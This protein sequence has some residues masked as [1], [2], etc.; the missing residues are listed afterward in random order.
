MRPLFRRPSPRR[1]GLLSQREQGAADVRQ[2]ACADVAAGTKSGRFPMIPLSFAQRR[3]WFIQ[4][5]EGPSA[6]Y[7]VPVS[8]RLTGAVD[9]AALTAAL[10]DVLERHEVLRTTYGVEDG[11]PHQRI[12]DLA[13][14]DWSLQTVELPD[15]ATSADLAAAVAGVFGY[16]FDLSV[17][18]PIRA[19]L[20]SAGPGEHA[21]A[22]VLH[23]IASDGASKRPLAQDLSTAYAARCEGR[24][25]VWE[26]LP[27]QYA[28]YAL[29]QREL[30][31]DDSDPDSMGA[32]QVA[33]W[34]EA[35]QDIPEELE[36]PLDHPRPAVPSHRGLSM[37]FAVS[38][39]VHAHIQ[40]LA[41]A[42]G[43]TTFMVFQ[44]VLAMTLSK[45]GAGTDVPVGAAVAGRSD[46]ALRDLVGF[47]VNTLVLRTD[48]SGDPTFREVLRRV[49]ETSLSAF[50]HQ[51]VPFEKLV[52]ELAPARSL[53]RHPLFQ[54]M[55][56]VE[57][58]AQEAVE[59]PGIRA[60]SL[61]DV[62]TDDTA[63]RLKKVA[64]FDLEI[65]VDEMFAEDGAAAGLRGSV[66]VAA[67]LFEEGSA[68][69]FAERLTRALATLIA[70]PDTQLSG[71]DILDDAER[72]C[73]LTEWNDTEAG[74]DAA[75][76]PEQFEAHAKLTPDAVAAVFEGTELTY[77]ELDARANQL[78]HYLLG[79]GVGAETVV[80]LCLPRG[81]D[82]LTAIL[83]IWKV[84]GAY[85]PLDPEHPEERL[86]YILQDS[87]ARAVVSSHDA[88]DGV[89][90]RLGVDRVLWLDEPATTAC[91]ERMPT[92]APN[93]ATAREGLAYVIYT[94]GS[95]G[96]PKGVA[97]GHGALAN[98]VSVFGPLMAVG[99]GVRVLQF[100]SFNFDASVLDVA[101]TL[102]SGGV[103]VVASA[104]E[105]AEPHLL[106]EL[107]ASAGVMSASVVPSLLAVLDVE[108]L[109][110]VG[111]M[112]V[113]SE[114]IEPA[115]AREWARGRRLLHAYGPTEATVITAV[116]RVDPDGRGAVPFGSPVANTQMFVLDEFLRPVAPGVAGELYVGGAQLARGYVGRPGLTAERFVAD[117]FGGPGRRLYRT[118][119][120]VRW[121][122]QGELVFTGRA[123]EQVK[124]RGFRIELGEIRS[125]VAA[126]PE[127]A[128]AA[129]V[130][131]E[132]VAGDPRLVAYVVAHGDQDAGLSARIG[133]FAA[134]RL[135]S[136]M[137]PSAVVVV[138]AL[139]LTVN[140]KLD[141]RA[142][143][144]PAH[145]AGSRR[146]STDQEQLL[147]VV[148]AQI[149][150]LDEVGA[151]DNFFSLGGHSL[152]AVR[153]V[154]RLRERGVSL[155]VRALFETPTPAGLAM[156]AESHQVVVPENLIPAD[157]TE[158][159]PEMLP[160]VD[161]T[162][163]EV[164]TIVDSV[165]A[166][167]ANIADVYPLAP[168]QE[169]LLFHHLLN[170]GGDDAYVLPTVI[171]FDSRD[172][173]DTF[174]AAL[175]HVVDRHDILRT[176][177]VWEGLRE[178]VQVVWRHA[179]LP[180]TEVTLD[181]G[182][183]DPVAALVA[184]GAD[185]MDLGRAPLITL[186]IAAAPADDR[187]LALLRIHHMVQ[188]HT[189]KEILLKEVHAF[190][191]G[192]GDELATPLPFRNFVAQARGS[193]EEPE[194][195][196]YFAKLLGDVTEP[197]APY[198][199]VDVRGDG[200]G[201]TWGE[202]DFPPALTTR[203][204][205]V[206]RRLGIS[207]APVLHVAWARV[208]AA[209]SGRNDVVFGTV[210][211]G[212]MNAGAGSDRVP[213][214]F[215]NTLPVRVRTGELGVLEATDAMRSQL[216]RLL[217]HEHA[218]LAVAQRASGVAADSP[219][220]TSFFNYR[221]N[222]G[223]SDDSGRNAGI[224][225]IRTIWT[226]DRTNYPL[227]VAVNDNG[228]T[229]ALAVDAISPI[230]PHAVCALMYTTAD[231]LVTALETALDGGPDVPLSTLEVLGVA[232][233]RQVVVDWND[234]AVDLGSVLVPGL[235]AAQVGRSPGVAAV[236]GGGVSV[237]FAE[238]D[239]RANRLAGYLVGQGVGVESVVGLCLPRG[240]ESVVAILA[241]WKAGA[242]YL[243]VDP[244]Y[245][246][247]RIGFMLAD[248]GAVLTLTTEEILDDLPAGRN[249][250]VALDSS[251]VRMQLAAVSVE[252]PGVVVGPESLAY[253]IYT[254][255]STGRPKGVA[256]THGGLANY[257]IWA[258]GAYGMR[259]GGG[260]AP[261]HSSLAFDLTVTSV[262][263]P[264]VSGF[265]VVCSEVGGAE[266]LAELIRDTG[267]FGLVKVVPAHLPLLA[268]LLTRE[269]AAVSA[270]TW[271]V[272]GE[273]LAG[274]TVR[275]WLERSP[276][277]VIVNEYG[278][279]EAVVGCCVFEISAGVEVGESVPVGRPIANTR[280]YVLD[281]YL[282]PVAPGVAG[283]LY[284]AGAQLARGYVRR[285][286]LTAERF[287]ANPFEPGGRMYRTGDVARWTAGGLL[288]YLGR[289]D[290]Q[291]KIHGF[292]IEPG[293]VQAVVAAHREVAQ[294]A[295]IAR[296]DT[297]GDTRLV[298]YIV[299][300]QDDDVDSDL[301]ESVRTFAGQRLPGHM[302]PSAVVVLDAL[303]LTANGKLDRTALPAPDATGTVRAGRG[304]ANH[305]EELLC[306]AFA[307][308]LGLERV[309]A[310]E[311]FF[312]LGGHSL[313]AVRL[314]S[315][316]RS[317]LGVELDLASLFEAP[318]VEA[319]ATRIAAAGEAR[320]EVTPME[321]PE[322]T[323]L[324]Y[325][326]QRLWFISQLEGSSSGYNVPVALSLAGKINQDALAAALF[327]VIG[328]HEV[329]R[330]VFPVTDGQPYQ[331]TIPIERLEWQLP[332]VEV[333]PQDLVDAVTTAGNYAFDLSSEV[334]FRAWLFS[335]GPNEHVLAVVMHHIAS[336]GWSKRPL[337][338]DL[339]TAY[340]ARCEGRAPVWEPLPVQY[341]DYALWQRE[342][343][344]DDS[345]PDS[346]GARQV[347]YW[348]ET[349]A[350]APEEL[351]LPTDH[352][353]PIASSNLGYRVPVAV[354]PQVHARLQELARAEGVT[355]FMLLQA[356][357]AVLMS[358]LGA[359][360]DI[361]IGSAYAGR[362]D[363]ALDDLVGFFV[364]TLVLRTDLSGDPTFREVLRRVR[365]T[366]LSAFAH[367]DV[368][369]EKLVEEL[370]PTRFLGRHPLFQVMLTL[371]NN[372]EAVLDLP[373]LDTDGP[374]QTSGSTAPREAA[375][376]FDLDF[377]FSETV[378]TDGA[379]AGL[380]GSLVASADL[381]EAE[382]AVRLAERW[383]RVLELLVDDPKLR[384]SAVDVLSGVERGRVLE[385]WNAT[386]ADF[387]SVLVPGLFAAQVG[388]SPGVA[389]VVGG[390]V[391]VSFAELDVRAN[392]LAGYLVGQGVGV[393]SVVG[394]CLPRGVESVVAI[395]AVWKAGA[396]YLP[397]DPEYP[398]ERIGFMLADSGAVLTLTTEEILDDLPAGRNRFVALDS[399]LVRMQLA[400]VSVEAPG[401]VV[402][403]ESLAYV[404][405]T[406]GSTG[407][408]KGVAVTHGGLAN[409]VI[410]AAGA[411]GMRGGGGGAPLHSSLAFD[412]TVTSVLVPLV[413]G[414]AVVCSE[415]GG[416]EGLAELIRDTGEFGLVK[417]VP[418]HLPLLAELLTREE[419]AV[420]ARTWVV[421]GEALAGSTVRDWL[422][423]SPGSVIVN[424]YGPT[425]AVVGCCVFEISA[426]V[427]VGE[428]VPVGRPIANTRLYV[429]DAYLQPVAPGV[430][431]ELYVAGA[432]LARGY[433]RRPGL[434]AERF[435]ANPF[436]PG[437]RM[438]RTGDVARWTAGGLLE[439][440]GRADEQV[441][442]HGFR[443]EP[444]EVQAVVA[445]HRE[446][447]QAAVIARE[448]TPG[449]TRLVAYIVPA[450]EAEPAGLPLRIVGFVGERLPAYMVPS[451]VVVLD[452]L[453]LSVNGK[454]DRKALPAPEYVTG[455]GRGPVTVQ[456]ELLCGVFAQV[457][458]VPEV[459]V[460]DDFF[461]LGGHSLLAVRLVSRIR[462]V[463]GVE[464]PLQTLF[465][466]PTVAAL[467]GKLAGAGAARPALTVGERP[468]RIP[469]SFAQRR[470]WFIGE[471]EGPSAS[472][473]VP[474]S[475]RLSG[476][477]D[478]DTLGAALRDVIE[479][480]EVLRT[481]FEVSDGE[482]Y[483][484]I[485]DLE[486]LA[487]ELSVAEVAPADLAT[488]IGEAEK[489]T[490]D[491]S[492]E[493]P[494]RTWL[495]DAGPDEQVL[496]VVVHHIAGDGWSMGPLAR[497]VSVAYAA[498][499]EGRAP[500]WEPLPVQYA[501][502]A[503]W[504]RK[505][506][507]DETDP[508]S[509]I[510][511]QL[512]YWRA[513]LTD[514]PVE[515]E[516]PFDHPRPTVASHL[517]HSVP[518]KVSAEVHDRLVERA[519]AEGVTTF[520][521]L[522]GALATL[523]C[524]L[525]AGTDIPIGS[526][527]AGRTDEA[528]D[529]LVGFFIN[530]LVLR[531]DLSGDPTFREVL[532]QVRE[533][534]LA[535]MAHQDVPFEKLVEELAPARS[536]A[537]HPLF[538]TVL[539]LQN[540]IDAVLELPGV[541]TGATAADDSE[542]ASGR[543]AV[544]FDLDVMVA[545]TYDKNGFP[546][547]LGGSVTVAAD[548]FDADW[549]RRIAG[550]WARLLEHLSQDPGCRL[551]TL[552]LLTGEERRQVLVG[553]ND[554]ATDVEPAFMHERF[555][556]QAL[557]TPNAV[558]I[559]AEGVEVSFAELEVRANR[560][561][562]YLI[563]QGVGAE[564]LVGLCLPRGVDMIAAIV[565]VWKA[566][567]GYLPIDPAQPTERVAFMLR[568][569][570]AALVL[571]AEEFL[572][573]L[574]AGRSRLVALDGTFVQMQLA[575]LPTE[576][577]GT[578]VEAQ[579]LA[580]VIYTSG[581]T[582]QPKGVA[583]THGGL[584]NYVAS[585]PGRVG[586][587]KPGARYA[588]LQAQATDL[589]NTVVFASLA[590]GGELHI[591][592]EGAVT[593]PQAV[594]A[595][596]AEHRIDHFKAVPSHL[597]AL[598]AA[599]GFD[600]VLPA[601][602]L[603]LGGEAPS[604]AWLRELLAVA[605]EREVYNH[606]G[607]TE[608]TIGVATT[609][610]TAEQTA[611][612]VVPVGTP[613]ANTRLYILD[614]HLRPVAP[615]IA[616]ELYVAGAGLARGYIRRVGLTAERFV[617]NPFESGRRMYRTG[618]RAK[619]TA[620]GQVVF[621]GRADDQVK[622]RGFRIE[623][624]EVQGVVGAHPQ[625]AQAVVI[626]REDVPG[627]KRLIAY[628]I[629]TD[630]D[631]PRDHLPASVREFAGQ[632][633]PEH[634]V[635]S[636][637]V[638]LDT[639]PLTGNGKL[640]RKALP[641]PDYSSS[642]A[643]GG[644]RAATLQEEILCMAF[645]EVLGLPEV[646]VDDDFF[647]LGG[648]SLLAVRLVSRIRSV[649]GIEV[650]IRSLFDA[651]TVAGLAAGLTNAGQVRPALAA[652]QRP[653]HVPLSFA[654][655]R[656]WFIGQ[657]E[658]PNAAYNVPVALRLDGDVD[659]EVLEAALRDV[660]GRHEVLRTV[661]DIADG[662]P[663]QRIVDIGE[664][665]WE[666]PLIEVAPQELA[667][668]V[669]KAAAHAFD[670]AVDVPFRAWLFSAAAHEQVL[671]V[672]MHHIAGDG[673]SKRPLARDLSLAYAARCE[674]RAPVWEPLPVQYADYA[675][676]QR[677]LLGEDSDSDS[678]ISR[679]VAYWRAALD[680]AP[681]ELELPVNRFRPETPSHRG[682]DVALTVPAQVHTRL[683]AVARAEG[684]TTFMVL[685]AALAMLLSKLGAGTDIPIG[686][687]TA[688][689][690][691]EALDDLVG[692]FINTL[693]LR[694]NLSGDPTFRDVLGRVR[695]TSLSAFAHQDVPFERLVEELAPSRSMG[696][697]PLFQV[698][699]QVQN[700][701]EAV[702]DLH[703]VQTDGVTAGAAVAK[704]DLDVSVAEVLDEAG[705]PAGLRGSVVASADLF[706][707]ETAERLVAR[708]VRVLERL[709]V[710]P[711]LRLSTLGV[712]DDVERGRVV[713]EWNDSAVELPGDAT[714]V[715]LFEAQVAR[716]PEVVAVVSG[717]EC[718]SYAE[719]DVR[720]NRLARRLVALGV[721]PESFVGV[722]L[723]RGIETVVALLAVLKSGGAYL[724]IDPGYPADRIA[725]MLSDAKPVVVLTS[726]GA[727]A[728]VPESGARV[729]VL[730][731]V[732]PAG[733]E[734]GPLGVVI[735]P[736]HPAYVIY[737]SGSTGRPKGVVVEHRSVAGL[738]CWAAAEFGG[739]DFR[740]VLV[741]TSFNFDVSVFELFGP[742]VSG[743]SVEVVNNLLALADADSPVGD[744]SL[745]SGV[746]SAFAQMVAA[747][748]I[749]AR[750]RTVVLA[751]EALTADAVAGIRTAIPGARVANIY[752][753]TEATVYTT[754]WYVGADAGAD[755]EGAV[756]IGRPISN[757]R[758]Y[759]LDGFL[760][761]VPV[762]VPGELYI[763]GAG[764]ARG[765]LGRP[766]L[767][768]ERFVAD[769]FSSCGGRLYRTGDVVR[770][771][772][773]GQVEYLGR[774]DEQVKIRGFRIELGEVQAVVAAHPQVAQAVVVAREDVPGDKRL[775]AYVV[776]AEEA[777]PAG[778]PLRIAEFVG[779][780]LPAY[781]VPSA[782]VVLDSLPLS[783]NGKLDRK[784]LPAPEYVTGNGRGPVTVQEELLCGVFAQVLGVPEVGVGDDFFALGGHSLLAV[785]LISRIRTVLG[786]EVPLRSLFDTPT[787]AGFA[788]GLAVAGQARLALTAGERPECIPLSF[789]QQRL[790]F[791]SQ[792]EGPSSTY[793]IPYVLRLANEVDSDALGLA[794]RDVIGRHEVL[795]TVFPT[796]GSGEPSQKIIELN[797]L[798]WRLGV[799]EVTPADMG[800]AV[801]DAEIYAFDLTSEVPI[802]ATLFEAGPGE[803]V[804]VVVVH[805][806]AG[807][808]WSTAPL[809]RDLSAAYAARAEGR[810]P[811]WEPLAV[812]YAD[813]ALWQRELLGD[814]TDPDSV[815]A[816]QL[817]YWRAAL[818][819]SPEE[820]VL[821]FDRSRPA[822]ASHLGHRVPLIVPAEVHARLV[823][824]ARSEGVTV[825]M[826]LQAALAMLLSRLGAGTDIPI[827][828]AN[829]GRTDEALDDLVGFFINTLV[830]RTDLSGDPTFREVLAR[831]RERSL[832][833]LAHQEVPFE[834]LVEELAP[835]RSMAR[836]P[837]FQVQLD[838]QNNAEGVLDLPGSE[839]G[840]TS[841]GATRAKFDLEVRVS[842]AFD[843]QGAPAGVCGSV[844][845]AADLFDRV[846]V[847]G[848]GER[849]VRV[850]G[851]LVA[852][853]SMHLSALDVLSMGE[854]R[855]VVVDW[856]DTAVD[857]GSVLVPGLF[858]A[859]VGRSPGVAA[860]VGGG[861]SVSFA[862]LDVRANR[863]A[864]YL[865]GQGVG[866]ES[867]VG[868]CLP[869]GVESVVAILAVWKA[870][871]GYL[872][873][874]PEYPAERI[875]F[876]LA[877]SGAVLTLT[878]EEILDD[879]PAGRNRFVALDSSLVRMQLAAA[880]VEAPGVVVGPE[881]LAYVIYT[882]GSTGRPKGVAVTHG[883][884]ANYVIWA[885]G[886]Y[887]MRGGGGGAPL[888]SSLAF[889]LTVTSVL[890]P[891]VS[892]FA[893]VC[894]EVGGAEGLA[895]LIGDT[896]E[897]GL[898]K[899]V[900]AHLPLLAELLTREEAAVSARTW[901][902]GGEALAGST[903]RDWLERS[904]G[905]VIV[906]EYGPTEAVVGCCVFEIS[907][908]VEVGESVPVGRPIANTR[909]YVLD[910]YL[911]PV[912][913]GVAGELYVAGAQLARGYV[914]RPGLTAER[915]TANPFEPGGRMYR[916]GDV[917]R[918]T[919]GGLLEYLGRADE[920]VKI[921]GFR[922]EP[923]E[924]Q[925]VVAAHREVAQAAVIAREDTPGDTRLVAYIVPAQDDE[926]DKGLP[927]TV[928]ESAAQRL[929]EYMVPAAVV[930]LD[931]LP[932]TANGKLDRKA[933]PAPD[934]AQA[935][936]SD[937]SPE[938]HEEEVLCA[939]FAH[940]LGLP[941]VGVDDDFFALGGHSLLAVRL[942]NRI[943]TVLGAEVEIAAVFD[944][945]T[946]AG[947]ATQLGN[948]KST[949][950]ALQPMRNQE[951]S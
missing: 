889:D 39:A 302:I 190:L 653:E 622:I 56:S 895:E 593:D 472:Y 539:T 716:T 92:S 766:E 759:V 631:E 529:D 227:S 755:V 882:S 584:A 464:V 540:T 650:E 771:S 28:D 919:A 776:P 364:N 35:L 566:G 198:G 252:A 707:A 194:H 874:D 870:G 220:F 485:T 873:V 711:G 840:G 635:P 158:V 681:E 646:G 576:R 664:L 569:S 473:N 358:R 676:W 770:W 413:S 47:F 524:Q 398:A 350:G 31:G 181:A 736:E 235:F 210:L 20:F 322:H 594:A 275:D 632:R 807:D 892:G 488:A 43:V 792:L 157:A 617:A 558:A 758:V 703:G 373:G 550:A 454:L 93:R 223:Q 872:P 446:V 542:S 98:L 543:A 287:T 883:G 61:A 113:G 864:G 16:T 876:M 510:A 134:G 59:L 790:W 738:L 712:L 898:V 824:V 572:D 552:D 409:Y 602:S 285:P 463:L 95:T 297:P 803:R 374:Q 783:V 853:P 469:L 69:T 478:R 344:G 411:Y 14:L 385:D 378:G 103:L 647:E 338:Q 854:R 741:S 489:Y 331:R 328:R 402:G 175:Q 164:A 553:W 764:L 150:G 693:V 927:R 436:E 624:G 414:F 798:E 648:H 209:V 125:T 465:E 689:R 948:V 484:R 625:V 616:G 368:P 42:E 805:H 554:T 611:A 230:A 154:E 189:A 192:H 657:L 452:S 826:V 621:L 130:V 596:L 359:G 779:D 286:G 91:L 536:M 100:A 126:C 412:L 667:D 19:W 638:V 266:G 60:G 519:R 75:Q 208:L 946:V 389:A 739:A 335:A 428:S 856:N 234:T 644:R 141:H 72:F 615:G 612:G 218:P 309:G 820:L 935:A 382:T 447:A 336:D 116:S 270:R 376:K 272:G 120:V 527:N 390:G 306:A 9:R 721:G 852:D 246:A 920:Q 780:R 183:A 645:A 849:L 439:Y 214:P 471:L 199:L 787:V 896:G 177:I 300:A 440:L 704:F 295:V 534:S 168:L 698:M 354:P 800:Y 590:T 782:V 551:S 151:D 288:E 634:M 388:R 857:L 848:I 176:S 735:R 430:A 162:A 620:D 34:R 830:V 744:V 909:L 68:A 148:F 6:T 131:R 660:I 891:L 381:F 479:R 13:Q 630:L 839:G 442:I 347:A 351:A 369:F 512:T 822:V 386:A 730:D 433:V 387:G 731:D 815:I 173:F 836:H 400:A 774:A 284:V 538:Q 222:A 229:I 908:G 791:I 887:G 715:G 74:V 247:E 867:V 341:A 608:T 329:L 426:G 17:E 434:T 106:R 928:R 163:E 406:S 205:E 934:Y 837:L 399:S 7:N 661:Y 918:W 339:S 142:L 706:D 204:R 459:G 77:A 813:Y 555:E 417:V 456:E 626:A 562:H 237:S 513:T 855:Q 810:V 778:L 709:A 394:L 947:L 149:L 89:A 793:N 146:P 673:W 44:A 305:Q 838:L 666:L 273:A 651:P 865:V 804:L 559:V 255:G 950:P 420:S 812:Q 913:P 668:A 917:A 362:S 279:T 643:S 111:S 814:E 462:T 467:T 565:G 330:T 690:T 372:A 860:V 498:R 50:A 788:A 535:A 118:G 794:L 78:A 797:E 269:E 655:R 238:L 480:H 156:A 743:G 355:V 639:L 697:H 83:G 48:L 123:D 332:L 12:H 29:W 88:G 395:L 179:T 70:H 605:G 432:Q 264:L 915:F 672:T 380:N 383:V 675:L 531:T 809:A 573:D 825:F 746:P 135:P 924:V 261:L 444:G 923:G 397:V 614:Q 561:A 659:R 219:V 877:D 361:P 777:E 760:S 215:M 821:P 63:A 58:L 727:V 271:V 541:Q 391:S 696:R 311:N 450:E 503:L 685:Q 925:A 937:R 169:G 509:L 522:Q 66:I 80:G 929:P 293:E 490:F 530:T 251:L 680:G 949:R 495:F 107:V 686:S 421:G 767:T 206:A 903:V 502:Y 221:H 737:T 256:V 878:T 254:S 843:E 147:C 57:H 155:S 585:V 178:P 226:Q 201:I 582:G 567:A 197:T 27:V 49:R 702:L 942:V 912:A 1:A 325:A 267:E 784:A 491:L 842:E 240:V 46:V 789:A 37:P 549:A 603:V 216:A 84:G 560:I 32:R 468:E 138:D 505:L 81:L 890:V 94:S 152:L 785:R 894:S 425:E 184:A 880:S 944:A 345:D 705:A 453:P 514:A 492:V 508:D 109:A 242:G 775:V 679:Q 448:D 745:V 570:R 193:I 496:V 318:T 143:P 23:H 352:R 682:H 885:A 781:M 932:L 307:Q 129:V 239:V 663:Y 587:G 844:V 276:G 160:L 180:V 695:E 504:Q 888:H 303:P 897:F 262:L 733:F 196:A 62:A 835:A 684:V 578:R 951:E 548:L 86:S 537:R 314:V 108:D 652:R 516:L 99:R 829:A 195:E 501:D 54:V 832:S 429:L 714:V 127:V 427:E 723:E 525:G 589:G 18:L 494:I 102:A 166:G 893:V 301:P 763:A 343:L 51:D 717:G 248:S 654:Q 526:A 922:I 607:P 637:V 938:S 722:C 408:P 633:L 167:A 404:I 859:Q 708:W 649:L 137:V 342:L 629:P 292:R 415:V 528:L 211:F 511:R 353:R 228:D 700:N 38:P 926:A 30:L 879:L 580:Y 595:Y 641:A 418:A 371:E 349:L 773:D 476:G 313:L 699:L 15:T 619:W 517:G 869:R 750:P 236:V 724:P 8:L 340:A 128:Q 26:P 756:P 187:W 481:V 753:P 796:A 315:R 851:L 289:A 868:L 363:E 457:L 392:R 571:T 899:V 772:Q 245:P 710:D 458:G 233:R 609:R 213:G 71:L 203:L 884:L 294:A 5:L 186:H 112:I 212:R 396:G 348:R 801:A 67:D 310:D 422:E 365:E 642:L 871:A 486:D 21:L 249:R 280:L 171:E 671:V 762:G 333:A 282:Q 470:L 677:D 416:A 36:L 841:A 627:D 606:Y 636:A 610:L 754:G 592:D 191:T 85:V 740:R 701:A 818:A 499:R 846:T 901:V 799:I 437:G 260:G 76:V 600:A 728:S 443:I 943:R 110:G 623:P 598:S 65:A 161:L 662:E 104:Q 53:A 939:V 678:L 811:V 483:Q 258:A 419:A 250:F 656:L 259:G 599:G 232:E 640:D 304:P 556:T 224:T 732:E 370:A 96:R 283:E 729:V 475:L 52:E 931:A 564:S 393:E 916:T 268:E 862:E 319:L 79:L 217:E 506:L 945:P 482:P 299:P 136:Y 613:I 22:V 886:A 687:A 324:S 532:A 921:H 4:Q 557:R 139:P 182:A 241:V 265:A 337:A 586:F 749:R 117:P 45:L 122:V 757:A 375:A 320:L 518:L 405:Y 802:R 431:G 438:Y 274:S 257:V 243:P 105:R 618:D 768:G 713:V 720:A 688:G 377:Q 847:E 521:F 497:D 547:G 597:A 10:R 827:G 451:A 326:Q 360:T 507:G 858:A 845:A 379:P 200:T 591:L 317:V 819:G 114:G 170:E 263:V 327:D 455:N 544:K 73:L 904:P 253:V 188:D 357:S 583:V 941:E 403:P 850:L 174:L 761:P 795:R 752:G 461:A 742:L 581:S 575:G 64:K 533:K 97:V 831:V 140:G 691:D 407:R 806:I 11:E 2:S 683:S 296:E 577:P 834:R 445:A 823:E 670:L 435:T 185:P 875:G 546:A 132:D 25:P 545:E 900:P 82:M 930:V 401:V 658:G 906:N 316:I 298:A 786:V 231:N 588:L 384:L 914:R 568:D 734:G 905:S 665:E 40:E 881:S 500:V 718:V 366:S 3:L 765:Y 751:G 604:P 940:V 910:A 55:L 477:V 747:G 153:L 817:A 90:A 902:V 291:V 563:G 449:D 748:E 165:D 24:A 719:L 726:V 523:L 863:L 312:A 115:L 487:W 628:V 172:R 725:Y 669:A 225:G 278:P 424:E 515:L 367:Q 441:K 833:A 321:R 124:I 410:W 346:M 692:F 911:Q 144:A 356:A 694:T 828:S 119:D 145:V 579:S 936:A 87:C 277:S 493:A 769:P 334:P 861:V 133:E 866:V 33:Y 290:E 323:P 41:R 121:T 207:P 674:G 574:P 474:V 808:G 933:L 466:A 907:A 460:G 202:L 308:V 244:E 816:T 101:V 520:M 423:R 601:G 281:A 159:T